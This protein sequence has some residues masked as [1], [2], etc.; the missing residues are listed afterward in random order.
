MNARY[1]NPAIGRFVSQDPVFLLAGAS[2]F[3]DRWNK[4]WRDIKPGDPSYS[5]QYGWYNNNENR[6]ALQEYL[7][8]PQG[9]NSYS[10]VTNNP[11]KYTD[12]TGEWEVHINFLQGNL[13]LGAEGGGGCTIGFASDGTFGI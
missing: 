6:L 13:G 11:L 12:P 7:S 3:T 5:N 9:L 10:Y 2:N 8:N 4:N 1:Q